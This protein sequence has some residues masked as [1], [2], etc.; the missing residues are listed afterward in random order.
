MTKKLLFTVIT[1][2]LFFL[3][4][5][6]ASGQQTNFFPDRLL[7]K[8]ESEQRLRQIQSKIN[9]SPRAAVQ[10]I[11]S[12]N[13]LRTS[14]PLL[15]DRMQRAI[16]MRNLPSSDD[17]LRIQEA[18]FNG[19]INPVQLA[20]KISAMP[21]VEY[22]EPRYLR[23]MS[24]TP[25][26][27]EL[28]KF[29]DAHNFAAAWDLSQGSPDILIAIVDGGVGYTHS[30]L[31]DN[32]WINQD[33]VPATIRPQVDQDADGTITSAEVK[34]Y[35]QSNGNDYNS[36]GSITLRDALDSDSPFMDG[37]DSDQ[38]DFTDDL[39]GW[40]FWAGG[41]TINSITT[42]R[43]PFHDASDHGTHVAGIAAA[44][45]NNNDGIAGAAYT[46][47]YMPVKAGGTQ[48]N[49]D[50]IGFGFEGILYAAENGADIINCSWG[51]SS[52]SQTEE[53]IVNLATNMGALVV[54]S[55]GNEV[56]DINYPARYDK[57]L[58]V[59]SVESN[60]KAAIY[61]NF[62]YD[63]DVLATGSDIL[64]TSFN[65]NYISKTGTSMSAPIVSGLAALVKDLHPDWG[66]ERIGMQIRASA[67]YIDNVNQDSYRDR[68]G[69]GSIDAFR[70]V[71]T[72][73]PGLKV[74]SS[75]FVNENGEKLDLDELGR[76]QLVLTNVGNTTSALNLQIESLNESGIE[77][78]S[79]SRQLGSVATGDTVDVSF[80]LTISKNF[81]LNA[82]P[83]FR[84]DFRSANQ[85][86][87]DFNV[88]TYDKLFYDTMAGN[89]VKTSFGVDGTIGFLDP[90][91]GKGGVGFIPRKPDG[92][93]GYQEGDNLLF[94]GGLMVEIDG[95]L[96]DAVR[97]Q[98]GVSRDFLPKLGFVTRPDDEGGITGNTRFVTMPTDTAKQVV[99][100]LQTYAYDDPA[101]SNVVYVKYTIQNL[102]S[103]LVMKNVYAGL[104]NDWD[105]GGNASNNNISFSESDSVL[106][107]ADASSSSSQPVAAVAHMGPI[108]SALAIDNA[109]EGQPDSVTFGLYDGFEDSEKKRS[110][111]A[112]TVRTE[113]NNADVSA[114]VASGPF[115]LNPKAKATIGFI[116]AFG[117]D[118]DEL[119]KQIAAARTRNLFSVSSA[120]RIRSEE[121]PEETNLF[122]N[123]PNPFNSSTQL[124]VD[125]QQRSEVTLT[126]YDVLGRKVRVLV[127]RE[128]EAGAHFFPFNAESIS[129]GVYFAR[130][131]TN[132]GIE[133]I[134]MTLIK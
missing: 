60:N 55:A 118:P 89:N 103:F 107:I 108:S 90:L 36:D 31:D 100:D 69:H 92:S 10:Q 44:E 70:A 134:P 25:N 117:E 30:E 75:D 15:S 120:G 21:G 115:T 64:S 63:L 22:A 106:Y 104:F 68:L 67:S 99:I 133:T 129:S 128:L 71:N 8:Y 105:I 127:D 28:E 18:F 126:I 98:N 95:A 51:G 54:V 23:T 78:G 77:L 5:F 102:S 16:R 124:H 26:D 7:I 113:I 4:V 40:D 96:H 62:G 1:S 111:K 121:V 112:G 125:L 83:T 49:A 39:F 59:G 110:L 46:A 24:Q 116:Y 132:R 9:A 86:Y 72:N 43:D 123:Y 6:N 58:S 80:D 13:G 73:L 114:V 79:A 91:S 93:G 109:V 56:T 65:N 81:D 3:Q 97:T 34:Q 14:R 66:P 82:I 53:E 88:I 38:N 47:T 85:N 48:G 42:D 74:I 130:L 29:I 20:A 101:I 11:L 50:A 41:E 45:T 37:V 27:T 2:G 61:S 32:L 19:R 119:R 84:L 57:A 33:E 87:E 35:L 94:E 76:I 12:K 131:K 122:Q 17:V 52:G